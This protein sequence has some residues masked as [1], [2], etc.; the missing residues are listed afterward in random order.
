MYGYTGETMRKLCILF[1]LRIIALPLVVSLFTDRDCRR[2]YA[3][4]RIFAMYIRARER[5][6]NSIKISLYSEILVKHSLYDD[7]I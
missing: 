7:F 2:I 4:S 5:V 6:T 3:Y 1:C